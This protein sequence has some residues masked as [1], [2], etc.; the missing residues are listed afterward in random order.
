M[1][2]ILILIL[3]TLTCN[4]GF[5]QSLKQQLWEFV[6]DCH[7]AIKQGYEDESQ[8]GGSYVNIDWT[9]VKLEDYCSSC[10]DD[11]KNGYLFIEGGWPACGCSCHINVGAYRTNLGEYIL[12]KYETWPCSNKF[13]MYSSKNLDSVMPKEF[14]LTSFNDA[15]KLDSISY[16]HLKMDIPRIG[17]DTKVNIRLFPLGQIGKE[18]KGV[19]LNTDNSSLIFHPHGLRSIIDELTDEFQ[20]QLIIDSKIDELPDNIKNEIQRNIGK[21]K[22][23][24]SLEDLHSQLKHAKNAFRQYSSLKHTE[25]IFSWNREQT[26]FE[27]KSKSGKPKEMT[28][29]QFLKS[30]NYFSAEC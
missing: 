16:F 23:I 26:R 28:F 11:S 18:Q 12:M 2:N 1:R 5:S 24:K 15:V 27:I 9:D 14:D 6:S 3:L 30:A 17:T 20:L 22:T 10:I 13:G 7:Q 21:S 4:V 8:P 25:M 19:S 29:Y